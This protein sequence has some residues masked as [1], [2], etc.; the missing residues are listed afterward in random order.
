VLP[1]SLLHFGELEAELKDRPEV[2]LAWIMY[3]ASFKS[4]IVVMNS[5]RGRQPAALRTTAAASALGAAASW[6]VFSFVR[7]P[8][9]PTARR[10]PLPAGLAYLGGAAGGGSPAVAPLRS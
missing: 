4:G 7:R 3:L 2:R 5:R 10:L 8:S 6:P 1:F 9:P